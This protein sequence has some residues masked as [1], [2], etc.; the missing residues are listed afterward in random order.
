[1]YDTLTY[2][3][4]SRNLHMWLASPKAIILKKI[5]VL[6]PSPPQNPFYLLVRSTFTQKGNPHVHHVSHKH[7]K[8]PAHAPRVLKAYQATHTCITCPA[9]VQVTRTC[10]T[11]HTSIPSETHVHHVTT[12]SL[13]VSHT[14]ITS[15]SDQHVQAFTVISPSD[16]HVQRVTTS[17]LCDCVR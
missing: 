12:S 17:A 6:A 7:E 11:C 15:P 2:L 16:P 1:M 13:S 9:I 14:T 4:T 8:W 10:T 3:R 5:H